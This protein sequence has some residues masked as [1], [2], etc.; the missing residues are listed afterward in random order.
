V[1][2]QALASIRQLLKQCSPEE[3]QALFDELR[4][5]HR[6][7]ELENVI[8]A[9][10][11]V[12]LDA[13]HRAPEITLRNLRGVIAD[14]A[15]NPYAA[16]TLS[17]H[18]WRDTTPTGNHAYD[19]QLSDDVSDIT[20]QVKL[21]RSKAGAP[22]VEKGAKYG[23]LGQVFIVEP[24]RTRTGTDNNN[25]ATRLYRYGDFDILAVC[26][27]PSTQEWHHFMFTLQ[28]WLLPNR[29]R[30]NQPGEIAPLQPVS[31]QPD[32]FWTDDFTVAAQ[33]LR[34]NDN[35]KNMSQLLQPKPGKAT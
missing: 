4:Q 22:L 6:I 1:S 18:G 33:W 10:A 15:F 2:E 13:I 28:K 27:Y 29:R 31:M 9:P 7:H 12:I 8:N 25:N 17:Q 21:Q 24:Q 16:R 5:R 19:Y 32:E 23:F 14:A 3:Q 35:G 34:T 20:I 26:M 30:N 11:E